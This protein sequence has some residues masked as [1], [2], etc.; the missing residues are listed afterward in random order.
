MHRYW[1]AFNKSLGV[2]G[3]VSVAMMPAVIA[4]NLV[5]EHSVLEDLRADADGGRE[6]ALAAS[7]LPWYKRAANTFCDHTLLS[8]GAVITPMYEPR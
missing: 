6:A 4:Y 5:G 2:S 8:F 1:P 3:K 7:S